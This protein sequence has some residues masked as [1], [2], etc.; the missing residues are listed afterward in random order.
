MLFTSSVMGLGK[1]VAQKK[2]EAGFVALGY[3]FLDF[4][5]RKSLLVQVVSIAGCSLI[6]PTLSS[7]A[8][9]TLKNVSRI[10]SPNVE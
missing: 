4:L 9:R 5:R 3:F 8:I 7:A 10:L 6:H 2:Q 1:E